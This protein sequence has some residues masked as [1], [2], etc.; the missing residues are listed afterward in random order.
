[1]VRW[2]RNDAPPLGSVILFDAGQQDASIP[3]VRATID[4]APWCPVCVLSER[5]MGR[6]GTKRIPRTCQVAGLDRVDDATAAILRA[7]DDRPRP[8]PTTLVEWIVRR[9]RF[10]AA[11]RTLSDLFS[12][13]LLRRSDAAYLPYQAR[14]H[15]SMLGTWS[16]VDW[17]HAVEFAEYAADRTALNRL[18]SAAD[19]SSCETRQ[20]MTDLLGVSDRDFHA[21]HGWEWVLEASLRRAGFFDASARDLRRMANRRSALPGMTA[22]TPAYASREF[23]ERRAIA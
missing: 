22:R 8:T 17:Q 11:G 4:V 21:V 10:H 14:E 7:V 23:G 13:P 5:R 9:T 18:L 3:D 1:M 6:R 20:R 15:L 2:L 19:A 16:A 12:R